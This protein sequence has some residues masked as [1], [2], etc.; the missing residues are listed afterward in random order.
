V[1]AT[2]HVY[3][4]VTF[5]STKNVT[6]PNKKLVGPHGRYGFLEKRK[7][8][9]PGGNLIPIYSEYNIKMFDHVRI[10]VVMLLIAD[11]I[12]VHSL[13]RIFGTFV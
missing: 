12:K 4:P 7:Q 10:N 2:G 9:N 1:E 11:V 13:V 5:F 8:L 3:V 6:P